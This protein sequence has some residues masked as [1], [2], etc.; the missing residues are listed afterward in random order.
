MRSN[1]IDIIIHL[2]RQVRI[3]EKIDNFNSDKLKDYDKSE[4]SAAYSWVLQKIQSGDLKD[5][6]AHHDI[7]APRRILHSAERV[8]ITPEAH[9]YL[10][11]MVLLGLI[12]YQRMEYI[13]EQAMLHSIEKVTLERIKDY[14]SRY[15]FDSDL[16]KGGRSV[17]LQGNESIN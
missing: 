6:I 3:G 13:I 8:V 9:G 7:S 4:I 15:A 5:R 16:K 12:D 17:Y 14:V 10:L 2:M 1:V 11:E